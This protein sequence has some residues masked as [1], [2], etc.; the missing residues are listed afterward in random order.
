MSSCVYG[1]PLGG[2]PPLRYYACSTTVL[3][4]HAASCIMHIPC[5]MTHSI[6]SITCMYAPHRSCMHSIATLFFATRGNITIPPT[7]PPLRLTSFV[8]K[9]LGRT[10]W[11]SRAGP[12]NANRREIKR[13][14]P[15]LVSEDW[16]LVSVCFCIANPSPGYAISLY[17]LYGSC[18]ELC[19]S[20]AM[21]IPTL[22][23]CLAH[24]IPSKR[25][26]GFW[27]LFVGYFYVCF[28]RRQT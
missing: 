21:L 8:S 28:A 12:L 16:D 22:S 10:R 15:Y 26:G 20:K 23:V 27:V 13:H 1:G 25:E 7:R 24:S 4:R 5:H 2:P 19:R 17:G 14:L 18:K 3:A 9:S 11:F 6:T